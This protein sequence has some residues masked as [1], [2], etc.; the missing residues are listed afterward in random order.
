MRDENRVSNLV[1]TAIFY[2][3]KM[4][5]N[6]RVGRPPGGCGSTWGIGDRRGSSG[7]TSSSA[8]TC[9]VQ[10][11]GI[12]ALSRKGDEAVT[13]MRAVGFS[14]ASSEDIREDARRLEEHLLVPDFLRS[15]L[16]EVPPLDANPDPAMMG[17][18]NRRPTARRANAVPSSGSAPRSRICS[19]PS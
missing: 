4:Q 3:Q 8:L 2:S 9:F 12:T 19:T 5:Q 11:A 1:S 17:V 15:L 16:A 7:R 13:R 6:F 14:Y 10:L 18:E